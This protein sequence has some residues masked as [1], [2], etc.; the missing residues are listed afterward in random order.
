MCEYIEEYKDYFKRGSEIV[1][2]YSETAAK[3]QPTL[4]TVRCLQ[5][6]NSLSTAKNDI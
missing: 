6:P 2:E 4:K 1:Q 5:M 3:L